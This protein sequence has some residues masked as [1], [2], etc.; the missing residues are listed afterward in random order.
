MSVL[1]R[2]RPARRPSEIGHVE[3]H[4]GDT[5]D[6]FAQVLLRYM[7]ENGD[8]WDVDIPFDGLDS[9]AQRLLEGTPYLAQLAEAD[10]DISMALLVATIEMTLG[11][12]ITPVGEL[13]W[14]R[15]T[16]AFERLCCA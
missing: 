15:T 5:V 14:L 12:Y 3:T 6:A 16:D 7:A 10:P 13:E 1:A 8:R 2:E 9:H 11:D 4:L